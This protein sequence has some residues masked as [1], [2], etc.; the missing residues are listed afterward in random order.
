MNFKNKQ[1]F[2]RI[3]HIPG[4]D[5]ASGDVV[6][7]NSLVGYA[8]E[9]ISSGVMGSIVI[10]GIV[11]APKATTEGS[12]IAA[13]KDVY[14]DADDNVVTETGT[15]NT[16]LGKAVKAAGDDDATV[17]VLIVQQPSWDWTS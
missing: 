11:S 1:E 17:D 6:I 7:Q 8:T 9:A 10:D 12:A 13:G 15:D 16:Y 4:S 14:W 2:K 3:A 5:V